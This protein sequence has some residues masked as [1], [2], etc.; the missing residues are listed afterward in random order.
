MNGWKFFVS[1]QIKGICLQHQEIM[2]MCLFS[3]VNGIVDVV[4]ITISDD[5]KVQPTCNIKP[6]LHCTIDLTL[7]PLIV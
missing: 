4:I 1:V 5:H 2:L 3:L 7:K 6:P